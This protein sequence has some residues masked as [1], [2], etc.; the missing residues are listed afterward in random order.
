MGSERDMMMVNNGIV[1]SRDNIL[2]IRSSI[3]TTH[4]HNITQTHTIHYT[5]NR[6]KVT[7]KS[8]H[9]YMSIV[10]IY[11]TYITYKTK[12]IQLKLNKKIKPNF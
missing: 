6:R 9:L 11:I 12:I 5:I 7:Q 10:E 4:L 2:C 3:H 8:L 1:I